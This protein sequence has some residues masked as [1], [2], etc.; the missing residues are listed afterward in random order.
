M[1]VFLT[2]NMLNQQA[3]TLPVSLITCQASLLEGVLYVKV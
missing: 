3:K 2:I 1:F